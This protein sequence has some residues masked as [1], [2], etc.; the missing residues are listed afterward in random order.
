MDDHDALAVRLKEQLPFLETATPALIDDLLRQGVRKRLD[1][2]DFICLEGNQCAYLPFVLDGRARVYKASDTGREITL[3]RIEAGES[4]VLTASCIL[5]H[6]AFPAFAVAETPV[7]GF[8]V[9]ATVFQA[10]IDRHSTWRRFVFDMFAQRLASIISVVEE[11]VFRRL[12]AR[13]AAHLLEATQ[14]GE[15]K[16]RS[17]HEAV[18]TELGSSRE[19]VSRLLKEFE[20]EGLVA[21]ERGAIT[22]VAREGLHVRAQKM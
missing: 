18:A 14:G 1:T 3:Y 5:N 6:I 7:E 4:C 15:A 22:V 16:V 8:L 2:G 13:L 12:D 19:V 20:H 9:P 17:T 11:V 10:W 21:L